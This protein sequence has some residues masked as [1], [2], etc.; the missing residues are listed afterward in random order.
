MAEQSIV[1][2]IAALQTMSVARLRLKWLE[3]FSEP[4][5]QR[6]RIFMIK[7]LAA[8]I[9]G[10]TGP[11]LTAEEEA[12]VA[13]YQTMIR[14]MPPERWFPGKQR[15]PKRPTRPSK[16][17]PPKPGSSASCVPSLSRSLNLVPLM[18]PSSQ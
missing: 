12:R 10:D 18:A 11:K 2:Q 14:E 7:R 15:R 17:Q 4:T 13:E 6:H 1:A 8:A 16:R 9:Q 5:R 3:V